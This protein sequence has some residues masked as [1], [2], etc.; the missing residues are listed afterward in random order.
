[1]IEL[2]LALAVLALVSFL[3]TLIPA[4]Y[5]DTG[6]GEGGAW[7]PFLNQLV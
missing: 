3:G 4:K 6:G 1:M 2:A 7:L 5:H